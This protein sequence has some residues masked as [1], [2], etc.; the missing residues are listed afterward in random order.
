MAQ[1]LE[2][3]MDTIRGKVRK[4]LIRAHRAGE[5]QELRGELDELADAVSAMPSTENGIDFSQIGDAAKRWAELP[6]SSDSDFD[7]RAVAAGRSGAGAASSASH[8]SSNS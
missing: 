4:G 3:K 1:E 6:T 5:L 2:V 7:P 8:F